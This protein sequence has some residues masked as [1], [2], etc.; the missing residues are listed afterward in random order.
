[1]CVTPRWRLYYNG[2]KRLV[3]ICMQL[4]LWMLIF[5]LT[6]LP[7]HHCKHKEKSIFDGRLFFARTLLYHDKRGLD[8]NVTGRHVVR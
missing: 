6:E 3:K 2:T 4:R 8:L 5:I 7:N 1:M